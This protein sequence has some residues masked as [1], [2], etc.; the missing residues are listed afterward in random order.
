VRQIVEA[1]CQLTE[2]AGERQVPGV[3][4]F[5]TF[6]MGGSVTTSVVMIWGRET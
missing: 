3:K 6:N 2:T 4:R 5:L 1:Y